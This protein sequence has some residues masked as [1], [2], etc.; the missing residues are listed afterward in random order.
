[1][2]INHI[3]R[4]LLTVGLAF[5]TSIAVS[6]QRTTRSKLRPLGVEQHKTSDYAF[7]TVF[8]ASDSA[9][10]VFSGYEKTLRATKESFFVTNRTDSL[11]DRLIIAITY[12]DMAGRE[13]DR[14]PAQIDITIEPS[15]TRRID[16]P[17]WDKQKVFY[18]YLSPA[19]RSGRAT[20]YKVAIST[21]A[22]LRRR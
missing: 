20:P 15:A 9:N 6:A 22:A 21:V 16:I 8:V 13:L 12:K 18:Y 11:I 4:I 7:D 19:P 5:T 14:R 1:M 3:V 17:A 10:I 2:S